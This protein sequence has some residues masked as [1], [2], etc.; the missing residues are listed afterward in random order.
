MNP[1]GKQMRRVSVP[2]VVEADTR[3][4]RPTEHLQPC[5]RQAPRLHRLAVLPGIDERALGQAHAQPEQLFGL[6]QPVRTKL[7][8]HCCRQRDRAA[9]SRLRRLVS[10]S[11]GRLFGTLHN[12]K[13]TTGQINVPPAKGRDFPAAQAA[14]NP[15]HNGD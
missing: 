3:E 4:S 8:N 6:L 9:L 10:N 14:Q 5:V 7:F 2:Q 13:P 1:V 12:G 15:K 11:C